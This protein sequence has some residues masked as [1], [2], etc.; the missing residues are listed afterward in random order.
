[1]NQKQIAF[2]NVSDEFKDYWK[3]SNR[4]IHGGVYSKGKRKTA[5]PFSSKKPMH[6]VVKSSRA[7]GNLSLWNH[8]RVVKDIVYKYAHLCKISIYK[9]SNNGNHLHILL[10]AKDKKLFKKF[11]RATMGLIAR[12]IL[13]AKK[14]EAKGR[15]WDS[16]AFTRIAEWGKS[17]T[18]VRNYVL[19]NILEA[20][21]VVSFKPR[22]YTL[23]HINST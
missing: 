3:A 14:G 9:Y 16:L 12:A 19:Q 11:M 8:K 23:N 15:F 10:R 4:K 17:Y 5:R 20:A 18:T 2:S 22:N 13:K 7:R 1:M 21:G 6:A